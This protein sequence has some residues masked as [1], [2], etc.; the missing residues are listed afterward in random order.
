MALDTV[1]ELV[2][3]LRRYHLLEP[4]QLDELAQLEP[5][6]PDPRALA[7]ELVQRG[8]LTPFQV[9]QLF[10][11]NA[12]E[13]VLGHYVL[14][15]RLTEAGMGQLYRARHQ[16][17][18]RQVSL[19]VLRPELLS[20]PQAVERFYRE[21]QTV[22]SLSH[23][24]LVTLYDAG[25]VPQPARSKGAGLATHFLAMEYVEG[26]DLE[27]QVRQTGPLP[28]VQACD[29]IVQTAQGLQHAFERG[30]IHHDLRP[31]NILI[32]Q[33]AGAGSVRPQVKVRN[34]GLTL[35]RQHT[36]HT[37]LQ[38][39]Q[40]Q[41]STS[42]AALDYLAPEQVPGQRPD[43]R[44]ELYSLGCTFYFLLTGKVP[45]AGD[46]SSDKLRKQPNDDSFALAALR[47]ETPAGVIAVVR[48]LLARRPEDR[49]QSPAEVA[50]AVAPLA[51]LDSALPVTARPAASAAAAETVSS[52]AAAPATTREG[53]KSRRAARALP[54]WRRRGPLAVCGAALL[55]SVALLVFL[56]SRTSGT[57]TARTTETT[58]P[59]VFKVV[60]EANQPWQ[61]THIDIPAG[62]LVHTRAQGKWRKPPRPEC[63]ASGDP[64]APRQSNVLADVPAMCLIA[65]LSHDEAPMILA[66][67]RTI[68]SK[69][70]GRLFVQ[71]NDLAPG[72][73]TGTIVLEIEGGSRNE[74]DQ[75][76][77]TFGYGQYDEG[78]KRVTNFQPMPY[79]RDSGWQPGPTRP[80]EQL[81]WAGWGEETGHPGNNKQQSVIRRWVATI[82]GRVALSGTLVHQT[83]E[84]DGVQGRVV[85]SRL[86][87]L[88]SWVA[89][90]ST[91]RTELPSLEVRRG[92]TIDCVVDCR[93]GADHDTF[94][95]APTL[96]ILPAEA[97]K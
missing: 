37:R 23:P 8:W 59:Q 90:G 10:Q 92:D 5:L 15:E 22:S 49:Y 30:L 21:V 65:R 53:G 56:L 29:V 82:D 72:Q 95:W 4:A 52:L 91:A 94:T 36:R 87:E 61:D 2:G 83:K 50:G 32:V 51:G 28:I 69:R 40:G 81:G 33:P 42:L 17:M 74:T 19:Q 44:A 1:N 66:G 47:P 75:A 77:W 9:N 46:G 64:G 6:F 79:Y 11:G 60:V 12:H 39:G 38:T 34:L 84:G 89:H 67:G 18:R 13:L 88:G 58:S 80:H 70:G 3:L 55:G 25:P 7:K 14:L 78:K 76:I 31:A 26:I 96:R 16:P 93:R 54:W 27:R 35:I 41:T 20:D 85:S 68:S 43:V 63:S 62:V 86:G 73:N 71:A 24:N 57:P 97:K 45:S 48:R